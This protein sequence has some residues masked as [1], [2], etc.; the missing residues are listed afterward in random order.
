[1]DLWGWRRPRGSI[2]PGEICEIPGVGP[3]P[4]ET[5]RELMGDAITRLVITDG[6]DITT[7]CH[8]GRS[9]P[10]RLRTPVLDR[11]RVC[12]VP[13][14]DTASG[15]EFDHWG[16]DFVDGGPASLENV[17]RPSPPIPTP[18]TRPC[19][20]S[21]SDPWPSRRP[22]RGRAQ[23][24]LATGIGPTGSIPVTRTANQASPGV[25]RVGTLWG[26][27]SPSALIT[28]DSS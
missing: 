27:A 11:D 2:G 28:R 3:V 10:A 15:L 16:I 1:M 19:S 18:T 24:R 9:I 5:A 26:C 4:V 23:G 14:C 22:G 13:G 21:R 17:A 25:I 6:V 12:V 8:L 20:P 7:V